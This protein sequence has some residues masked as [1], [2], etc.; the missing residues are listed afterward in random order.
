MVK[1]FFVSI[2]VLFKIYKFSFQ[3]LYS[4]YYFLTSSFAWN[5]FL[6]KI[7]SFEWPFGFDA[8]NFTVASRDFKEERFGI[9]HLVS[10]IIQ[11]GYEVY[12]GSTSEAELPKSS[13]FVTFRLEEENYNNFIGVCDL[14]LFEFL[15]CFEIDF[16]FA[17]VFFFW[18]LFKSIKNWNDPD[19]IAFSMFIPILF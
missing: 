15:Y 9:D 10:G 7:C 16:F 4:K 14:F 1:Y 12:V 17:H 11:N 3:N 8:E 2:D 19:S 6:K 13:Q 5:N 18:K